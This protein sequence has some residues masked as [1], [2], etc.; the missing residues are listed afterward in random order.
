MTIYVQM[1]DTLA[2]NVNSRVRVADVFVGRVRVHRAEELGRHADPG[3]DPSVKLPANALAKIGQTS[4]LGS[5]H[6]EL[7]AAAGSVRGSCATATPSR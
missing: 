2:L 1:P 7:D 6:V 5:Q 4:L 3:L